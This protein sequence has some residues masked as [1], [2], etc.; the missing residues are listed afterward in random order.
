MSLPKACDYKDV[1]ADVKM[2]PISFETT[3]EFLSRYKV[4]FDQTVID[5]YNEE[6]LMYLRTCTADG[7][8]YVRSACRAE[9]KKRINYTVDVSF[10]PNGSV[11]ETQCECGAG[12]GPTGHC[13]HIRTVLFACS[14]FVKSGEVKVEA[15]CTEKLQSFHKAKK[16]AGSP[17]KADNLNI[18]RADE[19]C[20][21][22]DF[23]PR[24]EK[25]RKMESYQDFFYNT[26][27]NF[28]GISQ[29][30]IFQTF[31]PANMRAYGCDHDYLQLTLEESF[32]KSCKLSEISDFDRVCLEEMTRGQNRNERWYEEREKRIQSSNFYRVCHAREDNLPTL[33]KTLVCGGSIPCNEKMRH[34]Q[35]YEREALQCYEADFDVQVQAC[36]IFVSKSLPFL[37]ASP[38]AIVNDTTICEVKCPFSA[39][40]KQISPITVPYLKL[41]LNYNIRLSTKHPYYY[42][43]QG[44]LFC[45]ERQ[46]C[47]LIIYTLS[48]VKYVRIERDD[49]FISNMVS[50]LHNFYES[51]FKSAV[52]S[53]FLYKE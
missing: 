51:Y 39:K 33:A 8:T 45:A 18:A 15:S 43:I 28:K 29:T 20:N 21:F 53:R 40:N 7:M 26:C 6:F 46:F 9:M 13:K 49:E 4:E 22:K 38:D 12:E 2:P 41:D 52:L 24:P 23:D 37:G 35:K 16:H 32:L 34:G 44:Q 48:D 11:Q 5:L 19:V 27:M 1:H 36:G 50:E 3:S 25:L 14:K 30:P 47:D 17:L 31:S 42:Q 10:R